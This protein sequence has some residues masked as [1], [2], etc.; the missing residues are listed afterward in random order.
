MN[1]GCRLH[2]HVLVNRVAGNIHI[3]PGRSFQQQHMH[4]HDINT[5]GPLAKSV[6]FFWQKKTSTLSMAHFFFF[7]SWHP[8]RASTA[9]VINR[10]SFGTEFPDI[11]NPLDA[12]KSPEVG[13]PVMYQYFLKVVPTRY[14]Y[15]NGT[16]LETNQFSV[17]QHDRHLM[18]GVQ[19]LPGLGFFSCLVNLLASHTPPRRTFLHL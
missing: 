15:L 12:H 3:A 4:I 13:D 8:V 9:H 5:M 7:S 1:E 16:G 10:L 6:S 17:T 18:P 14:N 2:G 19:G 11:V